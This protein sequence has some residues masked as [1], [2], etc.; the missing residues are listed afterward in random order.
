MKKERN[1]KHLES[2]IRGT[3]ERN[4]IEEFKQYINSSFKYRDD[5]L[6]I[7]CLEFSIQKNNIDCFNILHE[8][9]IKTNS[10]EF[11]LLRK[12][13][14]SKIQDMYNNLL[15]KGYS[16]SKDIKFRI[17]NRILEPYKVLVKPERVE[18]AYRYIES[19]FIEESV[20]EQYINYISKKNEKYSNVVV[21][22]IREFKINELLK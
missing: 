10:H 14:I 15:L 3:I 12:C 11:L 20:Y 13:E 4:D 7:R 6:M 9:N 18:V 2:L 19:G 5:R 22:Y 8:M 21:Q 16:F 1:I 17:I